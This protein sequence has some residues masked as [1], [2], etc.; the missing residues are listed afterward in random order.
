[1]P[2]VYRLG[3]R[4]WGLFVRVVRPLHGGASFMSWRAENLACWFFHRFPPRVQVPNNHILP[5]ILT[6]HNYYPKT[7]YLLIASFGPLGF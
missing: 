1:M 5:K 4:F 3:L 6:L 7:E 2:W